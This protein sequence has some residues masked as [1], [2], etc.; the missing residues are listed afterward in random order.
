VAQGKKLRARRMAEAAIA[1]LA[2][3]DKEFNA[4][5]PRRNKGT[6]AKCSGF[7][8]WRIAD[9]RRSLRPG[10]SRAARPRRY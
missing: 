1:E 4:F 9:Y 6:A 7:L 5:W 8:R 10:N 3:L 2:A